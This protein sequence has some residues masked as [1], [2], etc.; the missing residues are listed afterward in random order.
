MQLHTQTSTCAYANGQTGVYECTTEHVEC[1]IYMH[2]CTSSIISTQTCA[3]MVTSISICK[4]TCGVYARVHVHMHMCVHLGKGSYSNGAWSGS[5]I[6]P[7]VHAQMCMYVCMKNRTERGG[8]GRREGEL[9]DGDAMHMHNYLESLSRSFS[10]LSLSLSYTHTHHINTSDWNPQSRLS[11][12][13]SFSHSLTRSLTCSL[14][15]SLCCFSLLPLSLLTSPS[16]PHLPKP[17]NQSWQTRILP[18]LALIVCQEQHK[19]TYIQT[20]IHFISKMHTHRHIY[21][22]E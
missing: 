5:P 20:H 19:Q 6:R 2:F 3:H 9:W 11:C 18:S 12:S 17:Q 4:C 16:P 7:N 22:Y 8:W 21:M 13:L 15:I 10:V 1:T 14:S